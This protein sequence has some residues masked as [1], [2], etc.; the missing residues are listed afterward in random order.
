M[1]HIAIAAA[2]AGL[3]G[4]GLVLAS[5]ETRP[6]I[7][8][9][10]KSPIAN[11]DDMPIR[12][13]LQARGAYLAR[14]GN[15]IGCHTAEGGQPYAGGHRLVTSIGTFITPNI[16]PDPE[17]G[18]GHWNENDLWRA[19]HDGKGRNGAPLY[20]AFPYTEYTKVTREDSD[21]IFAYLQSLTPVQ[22]KN[23][24][25]Q[26]RFPFNLRPLIYVWRAL[27]FDPGVYQPDLKKNDEWNR[28]AYLVQG[29]GHCNACHTTRNPL[30]GSQGGLLGGGQLM[31]TNWYAPSLTSLQE[32]STSDWPIEEIVQLLKT[33]LSHRAAT[34]GPMADVVTQSLQHLKEDDARAMAVYLKSLPPGDPRSRGVAPP[35][36]EEVDKLLA[37]GGEIYKHFAK[38]AM[39]IWGKANRTLTRRWRETAELRWRRQPTQSAAFSMVDMR[40]SRQAVHVL[41][42]CRHSRRSC[43]TKKS[44]LFCRTSGTL[45][46]IAAAWLQRLKWTEAGRGRNKYRRT[47]S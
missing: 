20:P 2:L 29:L 33:G 35:L 6:K 15:C 21:A 31:G 12:Y 18:I 19:L 32:A 14:V 22:Q 46:E 45:G 39:A 26:I 1:K 5:A 47:D 27:Y 16:T 38:I 40:R 23:T 30:G 36:T 4:I 7:E 44:L 10:G 37:R 24:P 17:T 43:M 41:M 9:R 13:A 8:E 25:S 3:L 34:A 11:A 42:A 28:G